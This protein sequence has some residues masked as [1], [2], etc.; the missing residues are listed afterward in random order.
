MR[1]PNLLASFQFALAGIWYVL[2]TQRNAQIQTGLALVISALGLLLGLSSLQW[3]VLILTIG[4]VVVAEMFNTV[5]ETAMDMASSEFHPLVK[6]GKDVAAGAVTVTAVV[7]FL[8]GLL[9][10]GPP[11]WSVL[12]SYLRP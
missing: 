8:I 3:A 10:L 2:R 9:I 1:A 11:L 12:A 7:A 5:A 4:L 6:I